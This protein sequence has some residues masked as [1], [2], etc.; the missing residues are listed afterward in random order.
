MM[1]MITMLVGRAPRQFHIM[2]IIS[3]FDGEDDEE[4][5]GLTLEHQM[6][7]FSFQGNTRSK[8][9]AHLSDRPFFYQ[10]LLLE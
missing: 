2:R 5:D 4:K 10:L 3:S 9:S 8:K 6:L 7:F 1:M